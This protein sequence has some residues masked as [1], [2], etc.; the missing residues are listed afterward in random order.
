[1]LILIAEDE[2]LIRMGLKSMLEGL[3]HEVIAAA[4]GR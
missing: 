4:N 2:S 3:G 1:M